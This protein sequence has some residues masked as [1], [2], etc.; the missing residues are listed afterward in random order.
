MI[1]L[2]ND[3]IENDDWMKKLNGYKDEVSLFDN[4]SSDKKIID[5]VKHGGNSHSQ[6]THGNRFGHTPSPS[7][8]R[9]LKDEGEWDKF[10]KKYRE[11]NPRIESKQN[12]PMTDDSSLEQNNKEE[13]ITIDSKQK[14]PQSKVDRI[15]YRPKGNPLGDSL[16]ISEQNTSITERLETAVDAINKVHG[17]KNMPTIPI[18]VTSNISRANGNFQPAYE[19]KDV[20][21]GINVEGDDLEI[22]LVH[23]VGHFIDY[24]G[25]GKTKM[26]AGTEDGYSS[27]EK[28]F[29]EWNTAIDNTEAIQK[30]KK[31]QSN[32][33]SSTVEVNSKGKT[34]NLNVDPPYVSYLLEK[35]E[36]FARSYAQYIAVRSGDTTL[37]SQINAKA[38]NERGYPSQWKAEDFEE[39]AIAMD[40]IFKKKG[41]L[42]E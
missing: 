32:P 8:A 16:I 7:R 9:R 2:K 4:L 34:Y 30:L 26:T 19:D 27:T 5:S 36:I 42:Q 23:E 21:I 17:S 31:L 28:I 29:S 20:F 3:S 41:W 6:L 40:N 33:T 12:K 11:K 24:R 39:V 37:L 18:N 15:N 1:T 38:N 13:N 25:I 10:K 35:K 14:D 22:T